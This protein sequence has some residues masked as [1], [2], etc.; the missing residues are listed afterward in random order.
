[1]RVWNVSEIFYGIS[2]IFFDLRRMHLY[3]GNA[4]DT[5]TRELTLLNA[6]KNKNHYMFAIWADF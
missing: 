6:D 3:K 5:R 1:M 4:G 2:L